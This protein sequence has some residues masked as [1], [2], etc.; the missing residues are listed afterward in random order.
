MFLPETIH[1]I[2]RCDHESASVNISG[3]S[4]QVQDEKDSG[5]NL[6]LTGYDE[7]RNRAPS[8]PSIKLV[9]RST[10]IVIFLQP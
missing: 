10:A 5:R 6:D 8:S 2:N 9:I 4:K 1:V 3:I 7:T